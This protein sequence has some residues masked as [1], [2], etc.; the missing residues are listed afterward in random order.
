VSGRV[1]STHQTLL[2]AP[3]VEER[4]S[5]VS[6]A[7]TATTSLKP[8]GVPFGPGSVFQER[9]LDARPLRPAFP[10]LVPQASNNTGLHFTSL[11]FSFTRLT[12]HET[13]CPVWEDLTPY[14]V[15]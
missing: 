10:A 3:A 4:P 14:I 8:Q 12:S 6:P 15:L 9:R 5:A 2:S 1:N 13:H 11:H 7:P